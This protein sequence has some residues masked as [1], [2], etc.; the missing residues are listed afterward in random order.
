M[1]QRQ[2]SVTTQNRGCYVGE[3]DF[4]ARNDDIINIFVPV[5]Y[6]LTSNGYFNLIMVLKI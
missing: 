6:L 4:L 1:T 5:Q 2:L 3:C